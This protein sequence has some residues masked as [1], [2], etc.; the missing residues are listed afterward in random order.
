MQSILAQSRNEINFI[1]AD[2]VEFKGE[3]FR[4]FVA[5]KY[6]LAADTS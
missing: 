5:I 2:V 1:V 3:N 4:L 6:G